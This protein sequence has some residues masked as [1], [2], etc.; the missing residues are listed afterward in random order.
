MG[1]RMNMKKKEQHW[2]EEKEKPYLYLNI[3]S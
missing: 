1:E 3:F 2:K